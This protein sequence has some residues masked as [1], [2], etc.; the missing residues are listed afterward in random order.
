MNASFQIQL[1]TTYLG[2]IENK[3]HHPSRNYRI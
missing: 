3:K 2:V 1:N